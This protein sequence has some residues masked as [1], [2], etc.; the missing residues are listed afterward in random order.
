MSGVG[1]RH[2]AHDVAAGARRRWLWGTLGRNDIR[3][4]YSGSVLGSLWIT[5]N[6]ALLVLCLTFI[7]S[8]PLGAERELYAPYVAIGLVIW[9]FIQAALSEAATLFVAAAEAIRHSTI[10]LSIQAFRLVW[11]NAIVLA[12]N[13]A[14]VPV[15]LIVF[16]IAPGFGALSSL[17]GLLLLILALLPATLLLALLGARFRDVQPIMTN[18]LQLLLFATPIFWFPAALGPDRGWIATANP[19]FAFIDIVRAPLIGASPQP[20]SWPVALGV[21]LV[22]FIL[23][24]AAFARFRHR[25]AYWV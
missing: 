6:I 11:R 19:I 18:L 15:V 16:G 17:A 21:T 9:Y 20:A 2:A 5:A 14:I 7:F 1:W 12:H 8:G 13:A 4:R 24:G 22:A 25:V 23:A 10:P 3:Q